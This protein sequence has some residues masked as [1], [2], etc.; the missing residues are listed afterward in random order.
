MCSYESYEQFDSPNILNTM[1]IKMR[2]LLD[3]CAN[4]I[5]C[6]EFMDIYAVSF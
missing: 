5:L 2:S 3:K 6:N 4:G 1:K